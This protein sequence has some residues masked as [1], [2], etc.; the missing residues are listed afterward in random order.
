M[1]KLF[2]G[3]ISSEKILRSSWPFADRETRYF[4]KKETF[5]NS[6]G[7]SWMEQVDISIIFESFFW[8]FPSYRRIYRLCPIIV[9]PSPTPTSNSPTH[10]NMP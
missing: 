9:L 6:S 10:G 2:E 3:L 5:K 1:E 4:Q 8:G 7:M